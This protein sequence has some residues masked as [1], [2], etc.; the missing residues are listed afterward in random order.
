[1]HNLRGTTRLVNGVI[2]IYDEVLVREFVAAYGLNIQDWP[3]DA[4]DR[5]ARSSVVI[6]SA[7]PGQ[8]PSA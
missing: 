6:N 7:L 8:E 5:M 2:L 4:K 1:L 3:E